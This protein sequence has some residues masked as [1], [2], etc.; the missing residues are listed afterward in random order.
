MKVLIVSD[1]H[2]NWH[3]LEA[4]LDDCQGSYQEIVCCG[5]LVGYNAFPGQV[6][7]WTQ[8][9]CK[10]VIRGNHDKAVTGS[11]DLTWFNDVAQTAARWSIEQLDP[12]QLAYLKALTK[13]PMLLDYCHLFHGAPQDEDEYV[14]S[15]FEATTCFKHLEL[16]LSFFG[17][18]HLQGGFFLARGRVGT[19]GPVRAD[20][21]EKVIELEPDVMYLVN[22]GSV[23]QP[24]DGDPRAGYAVY[25]TEE[26]T[27]TLRR[28][29]YPMDD[30]AQ[31]I[32]KAGLP[33]S[34]AVRLFHGS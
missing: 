11:E 6:V 12:Q 28:T 21:T 29:H 23:G 32:R 14:T 31:A 17:H 4:V 2:A 7:D 8:K 22:P 15:S 19:I 24:R 30:A 20:R 27:V 1:L 25:D 3:A 5:D 13:G 26:R 33:E 10:A 9:N 16:P 34:L 18:T